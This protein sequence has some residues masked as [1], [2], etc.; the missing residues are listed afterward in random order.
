M[1]KM[2]L[3]SIGYMWHDS[4]KIR[5][6]RRYDALGS[7][8]RYTDAD[9][10]RGSSRAPVDLKDEWRNMLVSVLQE[11]SGADAHIRKEVMKDFHVDADKLPKKIGEAYV[12]L[13]NSS[14]Q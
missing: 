14:K 5:M 11:V 13:S 8:W 9:H 6:R 4:Q 10:V 2:C 7:P 1:M 3:R 12:I